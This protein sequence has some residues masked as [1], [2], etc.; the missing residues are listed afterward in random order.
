MGSNAGVGRGSAVWVSFYG[1]SFSPSF[2]LSL[3]DVSWCLA[4]L[5]KRIRNP[6]FV[7]IAAVGCAVCGRSRHL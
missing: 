5:R 4:S 3:P 6:F 2:F 1:P 7:R